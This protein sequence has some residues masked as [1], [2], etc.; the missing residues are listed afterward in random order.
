[1]Q[2]F[3]L[4]SLRPRG[5]GPHG[6]RA[7]APPPGARLPHKAR[8]APSNPARYAEGA[9]HGATNVIDSPNIY[10]G[11]LP[12]ASPVVALPESTG[13][14]ATLRT[15]L[16]WLDGVQHPGTNGGPARGRPSSSVRLVWCVLFAHAHL[17][18]Q[19]AHP[20]LSTV[21]HLAG[22]SLRC[23][24]NCVRRLEALGLVRSQRRP[25]RVTTYTLT[26][27]SSS[28][29]ARAARSYKLA[30]PHQRTPAQNTPRPARTTPAPTPA[31]RAD[32]PAPRAHQPRHGLPTEVLREEQIKVFTGARTHATTPAQN[33]PAAPLQTAPADE[34]TASGCATAPPAAPAGREEDR[35]RGDG[36]ENLTSPPARPQTRKAGGSAAALAGALAAG[37]ALPGTPA[38]R[39]VEPHAE[40]SDVDPGTPAPSPHPGTPPPLD[41]APALAAVLERVRARHAAGGGRR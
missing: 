30:H 26:L 4:G 12:L 20:A 8:S 40:P 35:G 23:V 39:H 17:E 14:R 38:P 15:V 6:P 19:Q 25:G 3:G 37:W 33:T 16:A 2:D 29:P 9:L 13:D 28:A 5:I 10:T 22:L 11:V 32:T 31:P 27:P 36:A 7:R 34:A 24:R 18:T 41:T 21:A 1:M